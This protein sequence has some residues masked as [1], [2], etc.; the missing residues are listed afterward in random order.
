MSFNSFLYQCSRCE[1]LRLYCQDEIKL[2]F[3]IMILKKYVLL[4][5]SQKGDSSND[6]YEELLTIN[7][8]N[9]K[10]GKTLVFDYKN[11]N[12]LRERLENHTNYEGIIFSSPRCVQ[13]TYLATKD[14]EDIIPPWHSKT[15][16]VVGEATYQDSLEKLTLKCKGKETGNSIKLSQFI[17]EGNLY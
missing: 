2:A 13:A 10:Q 16:F 4:L 15:N 9:V 14:K 3:Y 8:F 12:N 6:K 11:L 5:K 17:L 1:Y 7:G